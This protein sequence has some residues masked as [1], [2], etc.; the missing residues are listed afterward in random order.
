MFAVKGETMPPIAV[1]TTMNR[2]VRFA[3]T[4][5]GGPGDTLARASGSELTSLELVS[6]SVD[7]FSQVPS[8]VVEPMT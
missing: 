6:G 1:I 2:L 8:V 4:E 7:V 5:Y 3:K